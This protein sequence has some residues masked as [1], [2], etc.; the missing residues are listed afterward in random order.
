M[1]IATISTVF[2]IP[3]IPTT[4]R[5]T[6]TRDMY[7]DEESGQKVCE[8]QYEISASKYLKSNQIT[9]E[10]GSQTLESTEVDFVTPAI[11]HTGKKVLPYQ[12]Y[13]LIESYRIEN[14]AEVLAQINMALTQFKFE[15]SLV[16]FVLQVSSID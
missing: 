8:I 11:F 3:I 10:D 13:L 16:D 12:L 4:M 2:N 6:L 14:T 5:Y 9:N 1:R 15:Y 7:E